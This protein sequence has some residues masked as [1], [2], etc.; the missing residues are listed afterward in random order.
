[1]TYEYSP[2]VTH[3]G[4]VLTARAASESHWCERASSIPRDVVDLSDAE[5]LDSPAEP[6]L[7]KRIGDGPGMSA[8]KARRGRDLKSVV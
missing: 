3:T 8:G 4:G 1:M 6:N 2:E 5:G 7:G